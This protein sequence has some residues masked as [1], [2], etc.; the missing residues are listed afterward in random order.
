MVLIKVNISSLLI[1][2]S[3]FFSQ[4]NF[5]NKRLIPFR[6][7]LNLPPIISPEQTPFKRISRIKKS[8]LK[9]DKHT[10]SERN[11]GNKDNLCCKYDS[12]RNLSTLYRSLW[13]RKLSN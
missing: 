6:G 5:A 4:W 12:F 13:K 9:H 1:I 3:S 2:S 10:S 11:F 7:W 8:Y